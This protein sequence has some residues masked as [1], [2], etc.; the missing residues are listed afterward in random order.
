[1]KITRRQLKKIITESL[2][3]QAEDTSSLEDIN[4]TMDV[5]G[6][7][8]ITF[9]FKAVGN[10]VDAFFENEEGKVKKIENTAE[11]KEKLLGVLH[12]SI[13]TA[14]KE[15]KPLLIK[16]IARLT[17][18][19]AKDEDLINVNAK[20]KSDRTLASYAT[21]VKDPKSNLV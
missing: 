5:P 3:E 13:D 7:E 15:T 14:K 20:I 21:L 9:S 17:G 10:K 16:A 19:S 12:A 8:G 1:M 18:E 6:R 11:D 4:I 2:R